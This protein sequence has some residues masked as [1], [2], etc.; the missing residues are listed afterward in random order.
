MS[1][2]L[3]TLISRAKTRADMVDSSFVSTGEWTEFANDE[4]FELYDIL[5]TR[6][7]SYFESTSPSTT[8]V[9]G[10]LEYSL[11]S[12]CF[13][14]LAVDLYD[15]SETAWFGAFPYPHANRLLYRNTSER[16]AEAHYAVVG[17]NIRWDAL[18]EGVSVFRLR[19]VP[20]PRTLESPGDVLPNRLCDHWSSYIVL[21]MAIKALLKEES[22]VAPLMAERARLQ[23]RIEK[24]AAHRDLN[25]PEQ[26]G[27]T[28][29]FSE[30]W[31][32]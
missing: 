26:I 27:S 22:D 12:D 8:F 31:D 16:V 15:D 19:Y 17:S 29:G 23:V 30:Y 14:V 24:A 1:V 18:P 3:T 4:W 6:Y 10:T 20:L 21:G 9:D 25:A 13:K 32:E 2:S 28:R 7:E 11:P 5:V